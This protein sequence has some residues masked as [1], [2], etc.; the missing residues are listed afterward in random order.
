MEAEINSIEKNK[1]WD[2]TELPEGH[3]AIG[4]KWVYK[5]KRDANGNVTKHKARFVAK[6]YVQ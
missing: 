4:L 3:K 1:T 6:G 2:L 5:V